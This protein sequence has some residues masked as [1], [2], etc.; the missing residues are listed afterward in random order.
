[1]AVGI[2]SSGSADLPHVLGH[3]AEV[4]MNLESL[5]TGPSERSR[6]DATAI[7]QS[8]WEN[9]A[10][11]VLED[12]GLDKPLLRWGDC[13]TFFLGTNSRQSAISPHETS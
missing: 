9:T 8:R 11:I 2:I 12:V 1:M 7:A 3:L 5:R 4:Q 10:G 13:P 6:P